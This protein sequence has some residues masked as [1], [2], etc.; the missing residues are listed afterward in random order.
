MSKLAIA[1]FTNLGYRLHSRKF[2]SLDTDMSGKTILITG[3][4]GGLG[5]AAALALATLGARVVAVARDQ[6]KLDAL[7]RQSAG[8]A[9]GI[10][11]DLSSLAEIRR[12]AAIL[13]T[14]TRLA[15]L[16]N[17][18][19]VLFNQRVVTDEG[20]EA[21]LATNLA[22]HFLLTNLLTQLLVKSAP[23]RIVNVSSGGMYS[24]RIHPDDLHYER[25]EYRGASA[26]ARTKRGQVILTEM[27]ASQLADA[28]VVAH[29]MHPG[30]AK[31]AGIERSLPTFYRLM[32]PLLRTPEQGADTIVWLA[33]ASEPGLSTGQFWFDRAVVP[34]HLVESTLETADERE[35]LWEGLARL[36]F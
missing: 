7:T 15:V 9:L 17:N 18:V 27:W 1:G 14:E 19:G 35:A 16:I 2:G 22:G 13:A 3:A 26:Y 10:R 29:S 11:A 31:T 34:T 32:K 33:A 25:E 28:G 4:T 5:E 8:R 24:E 20:I 23:S 12:L 6:A 30:W 21:T 36:T